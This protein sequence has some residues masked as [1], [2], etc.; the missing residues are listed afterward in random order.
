MTVGDHQAPATPWLLGNNFLSSQVV[1]NDLAPAVS[2]SLCLEVI[3]LGW[4]HVHHSYTAVVVVDWLEFAEG[5]ADWS[6]L[7]LADAGWLELVDAD[8]L[9][10]V[11]SD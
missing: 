9:K 2:D 11:E 8:W 3:G 7:A 1:H 10:L 6:E 5:D 4:K